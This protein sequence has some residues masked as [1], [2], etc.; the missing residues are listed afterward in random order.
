MEGCVYEVFVFCVN[1]LATLC[2]WGD[3]LD[4]NKL[5]SNMLKCI[6][7]MMLEIDLH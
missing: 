1:T 5:S 3:L 7:L 2:Y 4:K 6:T